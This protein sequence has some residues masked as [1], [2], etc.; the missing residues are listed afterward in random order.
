[1][2]SRVALS[3]H[4]RDRCASKPPPAPPHFHP[5]AAMASPNLAATTA[6]WRALGACDVTAVLLRLAEGADARSPADES[7]CPRGTLSRFTHFSAYGALEPAAAGWTPLSLMMHCTLHQADTV[8]VALLG[9]GA[10]P[11]IPDAAGYYPIAWATRAATACLLIR[12]TPPVRFRELRDGM[13]MQ[14]FMQQHTEVCIELLRAGAGLTHIHMFSPCEPPFATIPLTMALLAAGFDPA[15]SNGKHASA[16]E[17][18]LG[19]TEQTLVLMAALAPLERRQS[20]GGEALVTALRLN[21]VDTARALI[22]AGAGVNE[23]SRHDD[24]YRPLHAACANGLVDVIPLLLAKGADPVGLDAER[25]TPAEVATN[26]PCAF[27]VINAVP[28]EHIDRVLARV[29]VASSRRGEGGGGGG[30]VG[31]CGL[32]EAAAARVQRC[33]VTIAP[34]DTLTRC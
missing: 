29:L 28:P 6:L 17:S 12:A 24:H 25:C 34:S 3:A 1:V 22:A 14:A 18:A 33:D 30:V 8:V 7:T 21:N 15:V 31:C 16:V 4:S 2:Y 19:S 20:V 27:A 5:F 11:T 32:A 9:A 10:D 13:L 26:M 23:R